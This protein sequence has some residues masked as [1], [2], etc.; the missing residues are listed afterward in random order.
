MHMS[1]FGVVVSMVWSYTCSTY[2]KND[3]GRVKVRV[4]SLAT[5]MVR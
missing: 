2:Y 4:F 5:L 3:S 1:L